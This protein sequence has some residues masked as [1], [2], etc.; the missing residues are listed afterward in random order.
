MML[1]A[2]L[3]GGVGQHC[4]SGLAGRGPAD[5]LHSGPPSPAQ[6]MD[7]KG[8]KVPTKLPP[9]STPTKHWHASEYYNKHIQRTRVSREPRTVVRNARV[10]LG[11]FET[12]ANH[13]SRYSGGTRKQKGT[14]RAGGLKSPKT[15]ELIARLLVSCPRLFVASAVPLG[16]QLFRNCH[17]SQPRQ[18]VRRPWQT[19]TALG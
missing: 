1:I 6:T 16:R 11:D 15:S 13:N 7:G 17:G 18:P 12:P 3:T 5:T 8:C 2:L 10:L 4:M 14:F 9:E 19:G